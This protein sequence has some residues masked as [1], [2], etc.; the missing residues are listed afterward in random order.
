MAEPSVYFSDIVACLRSGGAKLA[1]QSH[2]TCSRARDKTICFWLKPSISSHLKPRTTP[3]TKLLKCFVL[4]T[5]CCKTKHL[6]SLV[7]AIV[8]G[9]EWLEILGLIPAVLHYQNGS[10][11]AEIL[12][13]NYRCHSL[14]NISLIMVK[15]IIINAICSL[16]F[17]PWNG[18]K[19]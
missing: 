7:Q 9:F 1:H 17:H 10:F 4:V 8:R 12:P 6:R 16:I 15:W 3:R 13:L 19:Q 2:W 18:Q 14:L 11:T 5:L